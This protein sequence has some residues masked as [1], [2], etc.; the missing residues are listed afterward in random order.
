MNR[1]A[2]GR[3]FAVTFAVTGALTVTFAVTA[4]TGNAFTAFTATV[5][6]AAS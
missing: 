6:G 3:P 4:F 2:G 1:S 5:T